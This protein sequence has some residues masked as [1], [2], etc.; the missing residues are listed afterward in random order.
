MTSPRPEA[1]RDIGGWMRGN[2]SMQGYC[3]NDGERRR[4]W[5]GLR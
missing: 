4:L 1:S 5:L 3:I 2:L